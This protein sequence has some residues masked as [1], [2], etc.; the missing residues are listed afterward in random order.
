MKI[1]SRPIVGGNFTLNPVIRHLNH[2]PIG[3]LPNAD[4]LH[5]NGLFIGNHHYD[6]TEQINYLVTVLQ[7]F[8]KRH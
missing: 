1:E 2:S 7:E 4:Y 6:L 5:K 8:E 3:E